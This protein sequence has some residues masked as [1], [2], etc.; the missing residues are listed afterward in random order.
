MSPTRSRFAWLTCL[1]CALAM[2]WS[3]AALADPSADFWTSYAARFVQADGRVIDTGAGGMSHSEAEGTAML[4]AERH[5]DR[6]RFDKIWAWTRANLGTRKDGLMIW[7]WH[8]EARNHTP[9]KNNATDGDLLIAWALA[10]GGAHWK[11]EGLTSSAVALSRAILGRL[12]RETGAGPVLLPGTVG[13]DS[14]K[15]MVINLSYEV[16]PAFHALDGIAPNPLWKRLAD[17]AHVLFEQAR[18]GR[19]SL[20]TD[21]TFVP[22]DWKPGTPGLVPWP[23]KPPRFGYDAIRIPLYLAWTGAD[24]RELWPYQQFWGWFDKLPFHPAWV[25]VEQDAVPL[26]NMPPGFVAIRRLTDQAAKPDGSAASFPPLADN[27]DYFSASLTAL[28]YL[29]WGDRGH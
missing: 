29:A 8:P 14:S 24:G 16:L 20:P 28:S 5:D 11:D 7:G 22:K 21:W 1:V 9:D 6:D 3:S 15:G 25:D 23:E 17:T 2:P 10:E 12:M 19:F 13:F 26:D 4:L 27:E 18:R